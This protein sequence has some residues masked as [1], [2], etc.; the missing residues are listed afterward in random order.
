[1][2]SREFSRLRAG[3]PKVLLPGRL[4]GYAPLITTCL[5]AIF[6]HGVDHDPTKKRKA[7]LPASF[8]FCCREIRSTQRS[9][10]IQKRPQHCLKTNR[11]KKETGFLSVRA[12]GEPLQVLAANEYHVAKPHQRGMVYRTIK[13]WFPTLTLGPTRRSGSSLPHGLAT[14]HPSQKRNPHNPPK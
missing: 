6:R 1:M 3:P 7:C 12:K 11:Q 14:A 13:A 9:E 5:N 2:P 8:V 10:T 4:V